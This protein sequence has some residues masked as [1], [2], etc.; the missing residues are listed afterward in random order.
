MFKTLSFQPK[1]LLKHRSLL[2]KTSNHVNLSLIYQ[3]RLNHHPYRGANLPAVS[4]EGLPAVSVEG[5][6]AVSVE[7]LPA[8]ILEG[9]PSVS[10]EG[11]Y[12]TIIEGDGMGLFERTRSTPWALCL[13]PYALIRMRPGEECYAEPC[14]MIDGPWRSLFKLR[15]QT[16]PELARLWR[17]SRT[18][19]FPQT[20]GLVYWY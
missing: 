9:L 6:P 17:E 2:S 16:S 11:P 4:V 3:Y 12:F 7:G 1:K 20:T 8:V 18:P 14:P 19:P 10:V 13:T 5:L 15:I